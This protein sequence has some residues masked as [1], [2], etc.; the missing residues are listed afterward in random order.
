MWVG[1]KEL[2]YFLFRVIIILGG[3]LINGRLA[4]I[5][6][7]EFELIWFLSGMEE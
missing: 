6:L 5:L 7:L 3:F 2:K 1:K 4:R